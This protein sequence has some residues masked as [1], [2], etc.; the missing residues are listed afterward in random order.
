MLALGNIKN[1][2]R[3]LF[4]KDF[5]HPTIE[6]KYTPILKRKHGFFITPID[7]INESITSVDVLG[8]NNATVVQQQPGIG[9]PITKPERVREN[10]FQH[11]V[12]E[13]TYRSETSPLNLIDKT[14]NVNFRHTLGYLN[15]IILF[16]NFWYIYARDTSY[17]EIIRELPIELFD[18]HGVIYCRI[19]IQ[20]PIINSMDMLTF[21]NT[22]PLITQE[23]FKVE[24]KYSNIDFVFSNRYFDDDNVMPTNRNDSQIIIDD[25]C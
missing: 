21:D 24:F 12:S 20:G 9:F 2:A 13:Y 5:L 10:E 15:Y 8:F 4:P 25:N 3:I 6:K 16:E 19:M 11:T 1:G 17:A 22:Q 23:T 14:L 18:E 7:F